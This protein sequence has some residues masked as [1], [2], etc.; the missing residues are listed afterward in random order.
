M[1]PAPNATL[2]TRHHTEDPGATTDEPAVSAPP[3]L[4]PMPVTALL[5]VAAR[6]IRRH[7]IPLLAIAALFQLPS[8]LAR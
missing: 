4:T 7:A 2:R 6:I 3:R 1:G 8:S 5:E